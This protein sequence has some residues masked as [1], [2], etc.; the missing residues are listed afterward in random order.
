MDNINITNARQNLYSLAE[1]AV[2]SSRPIRIT[3]KAGDVVLVSAADWE[4]IEET[5]YLHSIPGLVDSILEAAKDP[6][7]DGI[8]VGDFDWGEDEDV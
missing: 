8:A 4:A 1:Q 5:L 2:E 7:E 3:S 6:L